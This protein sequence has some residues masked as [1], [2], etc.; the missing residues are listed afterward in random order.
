MRD[1][2]KYCQFLTPKISGKLGHRIC[3]ASAICLLDNSPTNQLAVSQVADWSTRGQPFFK[4]RNNTL[5]LYTKSNTKHN[6]NLVGYWKCSL[7]W[8][9]AKHI[10][11]DWLF[12]H[13]KSSISASW[14][15]RELTD[16]EL[17]CLRT[18]L[19]PFIL[20]GHF[21]ELTRTGF[22]EHERS[23]DLSESVLSG[24]PK[25]LQFIVRRFAEIATLQQLKQFLVRSDV[26]RQ[27]CASLK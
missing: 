1:I 11:S 22:S 10:Y 5:Y 8:S 26:I 24:E 6:S 16:R 21:W 4:S 2:P 3:S 12:A 23:A 18:V 9:T 17:V 7:E 14:L 13:F 20:G 15:V 25:S 19:L 27:H